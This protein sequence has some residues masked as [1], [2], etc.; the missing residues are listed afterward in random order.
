MAKQLDFSKICEAANSLETKEQ[1]ALKEF[2][3]KILLA[4]AEAAMEELEIIN[5]G[6]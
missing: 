4:K 2:I 1:K 3:E 5:A 6:K